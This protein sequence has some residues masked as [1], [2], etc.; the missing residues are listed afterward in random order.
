MDH[1]APQGNGGRRSRVVVVCGRDRLFDRAAIERSQLTHFG[2]D[3]FER[4]KKLP[5]LVEL[6]L[7][8]VPAVS[9]LLLNLFLLGLSLSVFPID[10]PETGELAVLPESDSNCDGD[11]QQGNHAAM[12]LFMSSPDVRPLL[13]RAV[14]R[15]PVIGNSR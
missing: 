13:T 7:P 2:L 9:A 14:R 4:D 12:P 15:A 1:G 10:F 6:G 11:R 5:N 8:G 3:L